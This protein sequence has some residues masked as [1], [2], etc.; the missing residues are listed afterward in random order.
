MPPGNSRNSF[1]KR[2]ARAFDHCARSGRPADPELL[3]EQAIG[4]LRLEYLDRADIRA[5]H[6][7]IRFM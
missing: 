6:R 4:L 1:Q 7:A 5:S 2:F 3:G